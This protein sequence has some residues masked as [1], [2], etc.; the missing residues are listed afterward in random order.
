MWEAAAVS[1]MPESGLEHVTDLRCQRACESN[2]KCGVAGPIERG[3]VNPGR[4]ENSPRGKLG[5]KIGVVPQRA[6]M[7]QHR[8]KN[9]QTELSTASYQQPFQKERGLML[10]REGFGDA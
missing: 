5:W 6:T 8:R 9:V 10:G 7:W 4:S 1:V 2:H 3:D